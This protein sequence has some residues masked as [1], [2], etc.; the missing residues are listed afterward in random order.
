MKKMQ[1]A[2]WPLSRGGFLGCI[3]WWMFLPSLKDSWAARFGAASRL[4]SLE[5]FW[6]WEMNGWEFAG[7]MP[8]HKCYLATK[9]YCMTDNKLSRG[10]LMLIYWFSRDVF[11]F[12]H[13]FFF[14]IAKTSKDGNFCSG[15]FRWVGLSDVPLRQ[16]FMKDQSFM[17]LPADPANPE[18]LGVIHLVSVWSQVK[19]GYPKRGVTSKVQKWQKLIHSL[20]NTVKHWTIY[21]LE[22]S[23]AGLHFPEW[24]MLVVYRL[25]LKSYFPL[26]NQNPKISWRTNRQKKLLVHSNELA[27]LY[28]TDWL[29]KFHPQRQNF[30][31]SVAC[32]SGDFMPRSGGLR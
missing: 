14:I 18:V 2:S 21:W 8:S 22:K 5:F 13:H 9:C 12:S 24:W 7:T 15:S 25:V 23:L 27:K 3:L 28:P 11:S 16:W 29:G 10:R 20:W 26:P 17:W 1:I 19:H 32:A 4:G 31:S 6:S 30:I